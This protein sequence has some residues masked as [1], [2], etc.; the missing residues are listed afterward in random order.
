MKK[1]LFN[2]ADVEVLFEGGWYP[3]GEHNP[4]AD[5]YAAC[6]VRREKG[7]PFWVLLEGWNGEKW[8]TASRLPQ[9]QNS[10]KVGAEIANSVRPVYI[11]D[12]DE[13]IYLIG[14]VF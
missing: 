12:E 10:S 3:Y 2:V 8:E 1:E 9:G 14:L 11:E 6:Y 5:D 7:R 4:A 13:N